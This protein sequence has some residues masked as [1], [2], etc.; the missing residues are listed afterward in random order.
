VSITSY[1]VIDTDGNHNIDL[2]NND[3]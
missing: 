2:Y 3:I 1:N